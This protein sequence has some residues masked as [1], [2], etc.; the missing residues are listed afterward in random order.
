MCVCAV[1]IKK[2][3]NSLEQEAWKNSYNHYFNH[4]RDDI[5]LSIV[6]LCS[7]V[8]RQIGVIYGLFFVGQIHP[9]FPYHIESYFLYNT[10]SNSVTIP[11]SSTIHTCN[12]YIQK[13]V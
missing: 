10:R 2:S 3:N 9:T 4:Y 11:Y 8:T 6:H 7:H 13:Y 1:T 12:L 5:S